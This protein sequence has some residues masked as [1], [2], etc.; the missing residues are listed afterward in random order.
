MSL[1]E[2]NHLNFD[3]YAPKNAHRHS[4]EDVRTWCAALGLAIEH[5]KV[6]EAGIT[7]IARKI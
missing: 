7:T 6:E 1:E 3:W 5:E 4:P 2:M